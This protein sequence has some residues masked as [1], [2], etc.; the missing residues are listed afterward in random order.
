MNIMIDPNS[1]GVATE[2]RVAISPAHSGMI[3][4]D[5][6]AMDALIP[7]ISPRLVPLVDWDTVAGRFVWASPVAMLN[8][9]MIA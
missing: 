7:M 2:K 3:A 6:D 5:S 1:S 4:W 9:G 8:R